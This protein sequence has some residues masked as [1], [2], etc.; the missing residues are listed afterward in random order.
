MYSVIAD[1]QRKLVVLKIT[2]MMTEDD[3]D[4][5]YLDEYAA[6]RGMGCRPGEHY[7]LVDLTEC[8]L[9]LQDVASAFEKR[10]GSNGKARR[11]AMFTGRSAARMQARR[12]LKRSDA[13]LFATREEAEAWL[14]TEEGR[15]AA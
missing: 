12:I 5:F 15:R 14:F 9:Q 8:D 4:R 11:L 3:V 13:G 2:G 7:A 10:I 1:P 6:I